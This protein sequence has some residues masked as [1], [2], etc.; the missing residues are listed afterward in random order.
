VGPKVEGAGEEESVDLTKH[1]LKLLIT[2]HSVN[3]MRSTFP[4]RL[5][6]S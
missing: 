3:G 1:A 2:P 4:P 6:G 5:G